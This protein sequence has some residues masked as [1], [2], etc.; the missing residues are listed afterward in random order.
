MRKFLSS[1]V[2]QNVQCGREQLTVACINKLSLSLGGRN[3]GWM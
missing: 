3:I 1:E 2:K